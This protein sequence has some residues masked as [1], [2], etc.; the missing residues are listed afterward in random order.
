MPTR[1]QPRLDFLIAAYSCFSSLTPADEPPRRFPVTRDTWFSSVG[2]ERDGNLGGASK[3][4]LKT[5]QEMALVDADLASIRGRVI[6]EG[7]LHVRSTGDPR[8]A[9]VTVSGFGADWFEGKSDGYA[10]EVGASTFRH[11]RHPDVAWT[12]SGGDLCDVILGAGGS[13]LWQSAEAST[14]DPDGWQTVKVDPVVVASRVA[15]LSQGFLLFDDTGTE[16][17]RQGNAFTLRPMPNR[18]VASRDSGRANAPYFTVIL[19]VEDHAPPRIPTDL[20]SEAADLPSGE[21]VVTWTTPLDDGPAGTLGFV[22]TVDGRPIPRGMIPI[23]RPSL[24]RNR[25]HLRDL[26]LT[27]GSEVMVAIRAVDAAGNV[28][29]EAT[30]AVPVSTRVAKPLPRFDPP[31][32]PGRPA[33]LVWEGA[34]VAVIDELD[35]LDPNTG[36]LQPAPAFGSNYLAANHVW[37]ASRRLIA[38]EAARNEFVGFQL[39]ILGDLGPIEAT[40][41]WEAAAGPRTPT[42]T[43]RLL[44]VATRRGPMP[45][46]VVPIRG[47][48]NLLG[49][50]KLKGGSLYFEVYVPHDA[51]SGV[52]DGFLTLQSEKGTLK[53]AIRLQVGDFTLPDSLSFLPEMNAYGL[54]D[55][56]VDYYRLAHRHRTAINRVPYSQRGIVSS[57]MAPKWANG[58]LDWTEWDAR[59]GPFFDGSAFADSPRR[60]IPVDSFYLPIHENWPT[61]I[62]GNYDGGYWADRAFSASY[63]RAFVEVS[64]QFAEHLDARGWRKTVFEGFLNNKRDFKA[65]KDGW[66]GGSSPWLLDEPASFQDF[67]ALRYFASAFHEGLADARRK[68]G[69]AA[70]KI[71]F[72]ADVSRP[73]WQRSSLDGLLDVNVVGGA[74][75]DRVRLV[76]D[77][78]RDQDQWVFEYGTANAVEDP[79]VRAAA[80]CVDAWSL[81]MDGIIPWQTIGRP[82]SWTVGDELALF[83]PANPEVSGTEGPIPSLR[84]KAFRRG[85]QDVEYLALWA[86]LRQEPRWA[87]G[88]EVRGALHLLDGVDRRSKGG[89]DAGSIHYDQVRPADLWALRHRVGQALSD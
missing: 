48:T 6:V 56:E 88:A 38:L 50:E 51:K 40:V 10:P 30:R 41:T 66:S 71:G 21:A 61:P 29:P 68:S 81:G 46:P 76:Q 20:R 1:N 57:E 67:W 85:Q 77:R 44:N 11:A 24:G 54:P 28:G 83:Y 14:P 32:R 73:E 16:W 86:A 25:L 27:P 45:D 55:R 60:S 13:T 19:G 18:F 33:P 47:P 22:A 65:G 78:K 8:L 52:R 80:W 3:L 62:E 59:F 87:V 58:R 49:G 34:T 36:E 5:Y 53:L 84:L 35:K 9:R 39:A 26:G 69:R 37:D 2:A 64:R 12:P 15:G 23:A 75:R 74:M 89:D 4:K 79:N 31:A 72:R 82:E 7:T 43:H 42:A 70:A 17:T 63:R